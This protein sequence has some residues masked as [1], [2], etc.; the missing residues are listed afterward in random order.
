VAFEQII[1]ETH[2]DV[3]VITLNRPERLNAWTR[4]MSV[5]MTAAVGDAND[6][7]RIGAIVFTG[8]GRGFCAGADI[9]GQFKAQ[10]DGTPPGDDRRNAA[11]PESGG[12][13]R[14][15]DWVALCRDS[16]PMVAAINGPSIGVGL[17]L[18]LP[19]DHLVVSEQAKLSCRFVK[20]GITPE[21]ASSHFLV[22]RCG[23]GAA[24]DLALSGRMLEPAEALRLGLVDQVVPHDQLLDVAMAKA[25]EYGANPGPQLRMIKR[26]LT[27]NAV[28]A[29]LAAVQ[30]RELAALNEAY[31]TPEFSEAVNA[32]LEKRP[33]KFR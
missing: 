14:P 23:W 32:F 8:A 30:R 6:D 2:D 7:D 25:R 18:V 11:A 4:Q 28:D 1:Y 33:A 29:D 5:E 9:G 16:K 15:T 24:S 12:E 10:L 21:L 3:A 22:Q 17:T 13:H 27:E 31:R 26:L 19:M 20:M